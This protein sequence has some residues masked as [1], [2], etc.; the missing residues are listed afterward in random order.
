MSFLKRMDRKMASMAMMME[1]VGIDIDGFATRRHGYDLAD[2]VRACA[3]CDAGG[4]CSDWLQGAP[5]HVAQAPEFCP[6]AARFARAP[7]R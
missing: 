6:N 7:H 4:T 2:A 3:F 5:D 1:K